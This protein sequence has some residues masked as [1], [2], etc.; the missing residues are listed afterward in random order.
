MYVLNGCF[1]QS[2]ASY[3][4]MEIQIASKMLKFNI[5]H[6]NNKFSLKHNMNWNG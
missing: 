2:I 6:N 3:A 1:M 5:N 4:N